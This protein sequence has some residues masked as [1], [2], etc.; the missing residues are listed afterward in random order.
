MGE[1]NNIRRFLVGKVQLDE[2]GGVDDDEVVN[3]IYYF[4]SMVAAEVAHKHGD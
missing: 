4:G 3:N 1:G 2:D